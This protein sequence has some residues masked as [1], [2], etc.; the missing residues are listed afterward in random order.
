MI[1]KMMMSL[2]TRISAKHQLSF[3]S[4][5]QKRCNLSLL[6][7]LM[8]VKH[9]LL[10]SRAKIRSRVLK[11]CKLMRSRHNSGL[12]N[13]RT[14]V[15]LLIKHLLSPGTSRRLSRK[16]QDATNKMMKTVHLLPK[17]KTTLETSC[18]SSPPNQ[19]KQKPPTNH[20][21][22]LR[23]N[24]INRHIS[25]SHQARLRVPKTCQAETSLISPLV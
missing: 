1:I 17:P 18:N 20:Q 10:K 14:K 4:Y 3:S 8:E 22:S 7:R 5:R 12:A 19:S 2:M 16:M 23:A 9:L 21:P 6:A 15:E 13:H 25:Q 11:E 24:Q